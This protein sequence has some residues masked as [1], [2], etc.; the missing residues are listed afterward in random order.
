MGCGSD[1]SSDCFCLSYTCSSR[2]SKSLEQ[3]LNIEFGVLLHRNSPF[4]GSHLILQHLCLPQAPPL[5][6]MSRSRLSIRVLVTL[7]HFPDC[8]YPHD[9]PSKIKLPCFNSPSKI[10]LF[11]L[12]STA[13]RSL[14]YIISQIL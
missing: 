1:L 6:P 12:P 10:I 9:K 4:H 3:N 14:L 7:H 2:A 5:G 8:S 11:H 13:L